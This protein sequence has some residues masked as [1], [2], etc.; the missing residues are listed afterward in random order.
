MKMVSKRNWISRIVACILTVAL[1]VTTMPTSVSMVKVQAT[2]DVSG[3]GAAIGTTEDTE[4]A[5]NGESSDLS[6]VNSK[7]ETTG[8]TSENGESTDSSD[9]NTKDETTDG[10]SE[11]GENTDSSDGDEEKEAQNVI[12][13]VSDNNKEPIKGASV[14]Y[15]I[16][17]TSA[18]EDA[19]ETISDNLEVITDDNGQ[20][21]VLSSDVYCEGLYI[22]AKITKDGYQGYTLSK[23]EISTDGFEISLFSANDITVN[24]NSNLTYTGNALE[25]VSCSGLK[26]GDKYTWYVNNA[27]SDSG[28]VTDNKVILPTKINV[29]NYKVRL[30]VDR[31]NYEEYQSDEIEVAI[32]KAT[33]K[34][35]DIVLKSKEGLTYTGNALELVTLDGLKDGDYYTWYVD[36][37]QSDSGV[38]T[39]N[40]V[41][42]PTKTDAGKYKVSI[43]VVRD[44]YA[45]YSNS[46]EVEI[47]QKEIDDVKAETSENLT[48]NQEE[49]KIVTFKGL[50]DGDTVDIIVTYN[51]I[52]TRNSYTYNA[53]SDNTIA[54]V[55]KNS[56]T[57]YVTAAITRNDNYKVLTLSESVEIAEATL[58]DNSITLTAANDLIYNEADQELVTIEGLE[59]GDVVTWYIDGTETKELSD[60]NIPVKKDAGEY[61]VYAVVKRANY[62]EYTTN[63]V[64][65]VVIAEADLQEGKVTLN[66]NESLVYTGSEQ[67]LVSI[68]GL[69]TGDQV[70]W[71]VTDNNT[72]KEERY[73]YP[74][75]NKIPSATNAGTYTVYAKIKRHNYVEYTTATVT[76]EI[77]EADLPDSR[78]KLT[79]ED[80]T[81]NGSAQGLVKVEGVDFDN[82]YVEWYVVKGS[83]SDESSESDVLIPTDKLN[84]LN[85][86]IATD[87][88]TYEVILKVKKDN[89]KLYETKVTT[90][91][92]EAD[93][94]EG[95]IKLKAKK[96]TYSATAQELV[97]ISGLKDGDKVTWYVNGKAT[98][99]LSDAGI[100]TAVNAKKYSVYAVV[101]RVNYVEFYTNTVNVEIIKADQKIEFINYDADA[102]DSIEL[103]Q[104]EME[105]GKDF[106]FS[107]VNVNSIVSDNTI[108]YSIEIENGNENIANIDDKGTLTIKGAGTVIITASLDGDDNFNATSIKY[109]LTVTGSLSEG[110]WIKVD[111][112]IVNYVVGDTKGIAKN[113][114]YKKNKYDKGT[115][116]YSIKNSKS[117]GLTINSKSGDISVEDFT[118]L[119]SQVEK[120]GGVLDITVNISESKDEN[121]FPGD[122]ISYILEITLADVPDSA[123]EIYSDD[124]T[125][126][127][128]DGPNGTYNWYNSILTIKPAAG[129]SVIRAEKITKDLSGFA[130]TVKYGNTVKGSVLDQGE[131]DYYIYLK[132]NSTG[133]I[134]KKIELEV[135]QLDT[136]IPTMKSVSFSKAKA[137][138]DS[139]N[140]YD[141]Y[142][143]I[144]FV[145][146]DE[147]S[148]V[149]HFDWNYTKSTGASSSILDK[150]SGTVTAVYDSANKNYVGTLS[151]PQNQAEQLRGNIQVVAVDA[152]GLESVALND[153]G[154]FV[155]DTIAPNQTVEYKLQN[156]KGT[157]QTVGNSHYF[158]NNVEFTFKITEA[159]FFGNDVK[160]T[161]SKDGG[162]AEAQSVSWSATGKTD[163]YS[164]TIVLS[165]DAY[166]IVSM[167]YSDR[168]GNVM[169]NYTSEKIVVDKTIPVVNFKYKDYTDSSNPQSATVTI[170]EHNFR[171]DDINLEVVAKDI[172]GNKIKAK[173]IQNY[174]RTCEW[175]TSGDVHT[176]YIDSQLID[177]IYDITINYNDLA[178]NSAKSAGASFTVDRTAPNSSIM[179]IDYSESVIDTALSKMTLGFYNPSVTVTFTA[180]DTSSGIKQFTWWYKKQSGE[181]EKN[182]A[183][184]ENATVEAVQDKDDKSKY[185]ATIVLPKKVAEQ[186]RGNISFMATDKCANTSKTVADDNYV[187]VVDTV[188]PTMTVKYSDP[189]NS[190]G[191]KDYYNQNLTATF[192]ITEA[193]F[194]KDDVK[195][196]YTKDDGSTVK[197][198]PTWKDTSVDVHVGTVVIEAKSDHSNDGDYIF[199]VEYTDRS[200]NKMNSYK[201][202]IKVIDTIKPEITVT[203]SNSNIINTLTDSENH[204]REYFE[205]EQ[206]ATVTITEHNFNASDVKY[207]ILTKN[208]A[209]NVINSG[210]LY[211]VSAWKDNGDQHTITITYPGDANYTFDIACT[212]LAALKAEDYPTEYF[213]V[214][215][216]K[217]TDLTVTYSNSVLDTVLDATAFG[218][219]NSTVT[220]TVTA[221]D[222]ISGI[223]SIKYSYL[224]AEGVSP[225]NAELV[226]VIIDSAAIVSSEGGAVGTATFEI[227][228]A[229]LTS[230]NQFNGTISFTATD[231]A[232][233]ESDLLNDS[234]RIVVDN[235]APEISVKYNNAVNVENDISYYDGDINA[236]ITIDEANF[237]SD[238]VQ[239]KVT[240]N[241]NAVNVSTTWSDN[242]TDVHVGTFTLTGDGDYLVEITY[243]D[244]STN[245]MQ[246][247]SSKQMT[248][249]TV[250]EAADIT[251]NGEDGDGKAFKDDVVP[252]IYFNDTNYDRYEIKVT[253][254]S[255]DEK[256]KDV[257][258]EFIG[259][260]LVEEESGGRGEF[261]TFTKDA[262]NDGIYTI[263]VVVYDK[264]G[265]SVEKSI[266]F[267]VNRFGSVYEFNDTLIA[268]IKDGGAYVQNVDGDLIITEYNANKLVEDSLSILIT[269]DGQPFDNAEYTVSPE[270]TED[271][272]NSEGGWY[273]YTYTISKDNFVNDGLYK[274]TITSKDEAGNSPQNTNY[275]DKAIRFTVDKTAPDI[276][277]VSGLESAIINATEVNVKYTVYDTVGLAS[278]VIM[279]DGAQLDTIT[280]F[281]SDLNNYTGS[282]VLSESTNAQSVEI[283]VTDIAGNVT[284]TGSSDFSSAF[285]FNSSVTVSTNV[286]VRWYANK[287]LF[288]GSIVA[289][290][291]VIGGVC[292]IIILANKKRKKKNA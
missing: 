272:N 199:E 158:S 47:A 123:Y 174:L 85:I 80:L 35:T 252:S 107:A 226:D 108:N 284:D 34:D 213:T 88:E 38:V 142:V 228:R 132:N 168:S 156:D 180:Y 196:T 52:P 15:S 101:K 110:A 206:V 2:E 159:N 103:I 223:N 255:F 216:T 83:D 100:A 117:Y 182:I 106:D 283:I 40:K 145:A 278:V 282:F 119:I 90:V 48:Y 62:K 134:T 177:G 262:A 72:G 241:G 137:N 21:V 53:E 55:G 86:P 64:T 39:D 29:G 69:E 115:I 214:D 32:S 162:K 41:I 73:S 285:D 9:V 13:S 75:I 102:V 219:Y 111:N 170:T 288:I 93:L 176:A 221:T 99:N 163:E 149:D 68:K 43:L 122:K 258:D 179:S 244:K 243:I 175:T 234:K 89:Y 154:V 220:V 281:G 146:T 187:V 54:A 70:N 181:S 118:K 131:N 49:Q 287:A 6:D 130:K 257:T 248:I 87:A 245:K 242:S 289:A 61:K 268:L 178:L 71:Y 23:T 22:E 190:Y 275:E 150:D 76:V 246:K 240:R 259:S 269:R 236:T 114:A 50:Q 121:G 164:A 235:I 109:T 261:N 229:A 144:T 266:T 263:T 31:E 65:V 105:A 30:V 247:Y 277:S 136:V 19:D 140:Y 173:D 96:L 227:P 250:I 183:A 135:K 116:S 239:V 97:S 208:V 129:Y 233:N 218:F 56:G 82:D 67:E 18:D 28:V 139:I 264:A 172:N 251:I 51:G 58:P 126:S 207:S 224:N 279:V 171:A 84:D 211:N 200:N 232:N 249:D 124:N 94:K 42:L 74:D 45:D 12:I 112:K 290:V 254:T 273:T 203:Y 138:K 104:S 20:A 238:D 147:T 7:D 198:T 26:N 169:T 37:E 191:S 59:D 188:A 44:N 113:A 92:K 1:V 5:E 46:V 292:V 231:R 291:V 120:A 260:L 270:I 253:R 271:V 25:L 194:F 133:M 155:V 127:A 3:E 77:A 78:V 210:S 143:T 202:G 256:D 212:D 201:S 95:S 10:A 267:S 205:T 161:V 166:Y 197:V 265:H 280:D 125:E 237:Y 16:W 63:P 8:E 167:T 141:D 27:Q 17:K 193:N 157:T 186:L 274:I 204:Q 98:K 152:A 36:D 222:N 153:D 81:Y 66:A 165:E 230:D 184:Y 4:N 286:F 160:I 225:A 276:L 209:G 33:L 91:I 79:A 215:T 217:P 195:V 14:T 128:L 192:T 185:T 57:Y 24:S 11:N 60:S 189:I 148:G 151:L